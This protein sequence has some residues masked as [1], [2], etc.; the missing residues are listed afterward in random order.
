GGARV[1]AGTLIGDRTFLTLNAG[2]CEVQ[3]G[4]T[5]QILGAGL[6]YRLSRYWRFE[7]SIE[8]VVRE[9]RA[10]GAAVAPQSAKYQIGLDLFLQL[11][12]Q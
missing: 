12:N 3:R 8:P 1:E 9:C 6:A 11:G 5:S 7:A 2:I 10:T 4:A